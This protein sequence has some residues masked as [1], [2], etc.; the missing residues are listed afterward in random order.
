MTADE[1]V[2]TPTDAIA[3]ADPIPERYEEVTTTSR[4]A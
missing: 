4:F 2:S 1:V 3:S